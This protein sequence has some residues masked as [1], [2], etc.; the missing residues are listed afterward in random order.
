M[1]AAHRLFFAI[2]PPTAVRERIAALAKE[3]QPAHGIGG[4]LL[5]AGRYHLTLQFLGGFDE[6][7]PPQLA[8]AHAAGNE[9]RFA[10]F[11]LSLDRLGSFP[12]RQQSPFY[13]GCLEVPDA[14][15][16]LYGQIRSHLRSVGW[17]QPLGRGFVPHLTL[18]YG[19]HALPLPVA[20]PPVSFA[21]DA[22]QLYRSSTGQ[23]GFSRLGQWL[24][25]GVGVST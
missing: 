23:S 16:A 5:D 12:R 20:V 17:T 19:R 1:P 6:A 21:V 15:Q 25:D 2:T 14:L 7:E 4:R 10:P 3:W 13:L 9:L 8:L 11:E 18:A 22:V 24:A